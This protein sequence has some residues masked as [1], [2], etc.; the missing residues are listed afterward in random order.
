MID[1]IK[2]LYFKNKGKYTTNSDAVIIACYY[3]PQRN[4]YRKKAFDL[5][6]ESVKHLNVRIIEAT[7][8]DVPYE[9]DS[10]IVSK[11]V[12]LDE[13]LWYKEYLLNLLI[14]D[15]PKKYKYVFWLDTDIIF[16]N[17]N[18]LVESCE[19]LKKYKVVQPFTYCTHLDKHDYTGESTILSLLEQKN[20]L[21]DDIPNRKKWRSYCSN[22]YTS[23]NDDKKY[24]VRGHV[25]FAWGCRREVLDYQLLFENAKIGGADGIIAYACKSPIVCSSISDMF[26]CRQ[27][28]ID[29]TSA[30]YQIVQGSVSCVQG[31]LLHLWHGDTKKREYYKRIK[32]FSK[33]TE[34]EQLT[35]FSNYMNKREVVED[36]VKE[37]Y[38]SVFIPDILNISGLYNTITIDSDNTITGHV[39]DFGGGDFD[40][41]GA[42]GDWGNDTNNNFENFS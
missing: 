20:Y 18:W 29:F 41:G 21:N 40:G 4:D 36:V 17:K 30:W 13:W 34:E 37:D 2:N 42:E 19:Q 27:D 11:Q 16:K 10:K 28:I 1:T 39:L 32:E 24:D 22:F 7:L 31:D 8:K 5:W 38:P 23:L 9:L 3:N 12:V 33:I 35:Y 25:G 26:G 15:L 14:K 6:Y